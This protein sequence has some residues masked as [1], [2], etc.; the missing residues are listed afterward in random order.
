MT[1]KNKIKTFFTMDDEY[2]YVEEYEQE[3][4]PASSSESTN[5][6][7]SKQNVVNLKSMQQTASKVVLSEPRSYGEAQEIADNIVNRRAVVINLQRVDR[8]Q[9]KR[10]V[11]FLSGTVYAINGDIQKLG[12][13]TFLCTPD[14]VNVSG[15]ITDTLVE[16]D[17]FEKGW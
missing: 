16:E 1:I 7:Q 15:S 2:E 10:I 5:Q 11:D 9:A 4:A 17:E 14:N 13:D 6:K 3:D 8:G 12:A